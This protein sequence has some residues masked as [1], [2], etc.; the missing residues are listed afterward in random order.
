MKCAAAKPEQNHNEIIVHNFA[1]YVCTMLYHVNSISLQWRHNERDG[2]SNQQPHDCLL[3]RLF[4]H[5]SKK[6]Q[7]TGFC[8]VSGDRWIPRKKGQ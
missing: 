4:R 7:S 1:V 3:N 2:V 5:M 8:A 6:Y